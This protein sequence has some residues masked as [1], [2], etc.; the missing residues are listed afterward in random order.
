MSELILVKRVIKKY[1]TLLENL[2]LAKS[3]NINM[4]KITF[5]VNK[6]RYCVL[7][8]RCKFFYKIL[9]K[10]KSTRPYVEKTWEKELCMNFTS[11]DW[12]KVYMNRVHNIPINKISEFMYKLIQKLTV[13]RQILRKW[14]KTD[15][16]QCPVCNDI[17]T[18][19]HIYFECPRVNEMWR[20]LGSVVK[21]D[22]TWK[23]IVFGYIEDI[24]PHKI[25]NLLF[26]V[27]LYG[28]FKNWMSSFDDQTK[29]VCANIL[30]VIKAELKT[31]T[32]WFKDK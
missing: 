5:V 25:R 17:E 30:N 8:Q 23:K 6:K 18:V 9:V 12:S 28:L 20:K 27:I 19:K 21:I 2:S 7:N 3:V 10:N 4:D 29:Y 14:N 11:F 26:S 16:D 24:M 22:I 13:C 32:F 1:D 15:T 31:R